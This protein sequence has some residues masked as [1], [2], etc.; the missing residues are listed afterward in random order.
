MKIGSGEENAKAIGQMLEKLL[1]EKTA[2]GE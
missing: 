1:G 2:S